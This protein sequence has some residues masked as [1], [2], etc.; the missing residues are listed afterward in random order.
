M[1]HLMSCRILGVKIAFQGLQKTGIP[2]IGFNGNV[3]SPGEGA[4]PP[5]IFLYIPLIMKLAH[6]SLQ[7]G[8]NAFFFSLIALAFLSGATALFLLYRGWSRIFS[9]SGLVIVSAAAVA[10]GDLYTAL[11][12]SVAATVPWAIYFWERKRPDKLY[13][14]YLVMAGVFLGLMNT[15]RLHGGT[16]ALLFIGILLFAGMKTQLARRL[17]LGAFLLAGFLLPLGAMHIVTSHRDGFLTEKQ[18][19]YVTSVHPFW[20]SI[21]TGMG[22]LS[23]TEIPGYNDNVS[24]DAAR[25]VDPKVVECSREYEQILRNATVHF[26][27]HSPKSLFFFWMTLCAKLGVVLGYFVIFANVG[28]VSALRYRKPLVL[29]LAFAGALLYGLL[30][31]LLVVPYPDYLLEF[32]TLSALYGAVSFGYGRHAKHLAEN[33]LAMAELCAA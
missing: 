4:D 27:F 28:I 13:A 32:I 20:H 25:R 7:S 26:I 15:I 10:F 17:A 18:P 3:F 21:Y 29:E 24:I 16:A 22:F 5:G 19:G 12:A 14:I 33:P 30:P 11:F 2:L 8:I 1:I 23:N 9:V 6:L 31:G